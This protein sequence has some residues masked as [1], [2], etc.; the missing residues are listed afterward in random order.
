[1]PSAGGVVC[2]RAIDGNAR[3]AARMTMMARETMSVQYTR[4]TVT[5]R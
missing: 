1:M 5:T 2:A 3:N 4:Q